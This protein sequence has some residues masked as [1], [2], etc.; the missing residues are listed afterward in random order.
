MSGA[1]KW[2]VALLLA[3]NAV[4]YLWTGEAPDYDAQA[5]SAQPEVNREGMLLLDELD[6]A[7]GAPALATDSP[8]S[9]SKTPRQISVAPTAAADLSCYRIGPFRKEPGWLDANRWMR[10]RQFSYQAVRGESREM[11]AVRVY[12]GPFDSP[13]AAQPMMNWL[14]E[15]GIEHFISQ[16]TS[17]RA[18]ISL[19]YFTQEA[20]AVKF[21]AHLLSRGVE[22]NSKPEYRAM[23]PFNWMEASIDIARRDVLLSHHWPARGVAVLEIRCSEIAPPGN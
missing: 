3:A 14:T 17:G 20:L 2:S 19:G 8:A 7:G 16:E 21:V 6:A 9:V 13:A 5:P 11:R 12:L 15:R 10:A 18:H 4:F 22:A 23:G 1:L